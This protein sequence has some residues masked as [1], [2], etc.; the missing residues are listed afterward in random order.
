MP[1][2]GAPGP[3]LRLPGRGAPG[4]PKPKATVSLG[5]VR[6]QGATV[7]NAERVVAGMRA[8]F[9]NCYERGLAE[10]A[11][12]AGGLRLSLAVGPQGVV[13]DVDVKQ[14]GQ[15]ISAAVKDCIV[16][17]AQFAQFDRPE[18]ASSAQIEFAATLKLEPPKSE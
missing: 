1:V 8:G 18:G 15:A 11:N 10:D 12:M 5:A 16:G 6:V 3:G 17:R 14:T 13:V 7:A 9:R 2:Y 4:P